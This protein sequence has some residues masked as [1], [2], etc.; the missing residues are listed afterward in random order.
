MAWFEGLYFKMETDEGETLSLIPSLHLGDDGLRRAHLQA[1]TPQGSARWDLSDRPA[2]ISEDGLTLRLG[3]HTFSPHGITLRDASADLYGQ[4]RFHGLT[5]LSCDIMGPFALLPGM[6]CRHRVVS[7][8]HRVTGQLH[9]EGRSYRF[10]DGLGYLEGDA[11]SAF[12]RRY[13]WLHG[14]TRRPCVSL[15]LAVA[16]IPLGR[17]GFDGVIALVSDGSRRRRLATYLGAAAHVTPGAITVTQGS[18]HLQVT[19][20]DLP[21]GRPLL[22]PD[23]GLMTRSI[24]EILSTPAH[25]TLRRGS[26]TLLDTVLPQ[27]SAEWEWTN[28]EEE[29]AEDRPPAAGS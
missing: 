23:R 24:R 18:T 10:V 19:L 2:S 22:A 12:P 25:V 20:P 14:A 27:T 4:V 6:E 3:S 17:T 16:E 28:R 1:V 11:G 9:L 8:R 26:T 5:P 7:L 21:P 15:M 13:L 29:R